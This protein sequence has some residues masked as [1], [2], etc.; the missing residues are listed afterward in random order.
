[1]AARPEAL[2][3]DVAFQKEVANVAK[4]VTTA[5]ALLRQGRLSAPDAG[6]HQP[7]PK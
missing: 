3:R 4:A 5:V 6:L 2:E 7:R 1:M